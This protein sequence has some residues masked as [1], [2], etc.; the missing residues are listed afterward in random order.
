MLAPYPRA[1]EFPADPDAERQV[2]ALKAVVLGIRQ[3][4]GELDVPHSRS[5][6]VFVQT[7]REGDSAALAALAG[8]IAKVANLESV[9]VVASE[10]E[11]PPCAI[12]IIDGR[13]IFAPFARLV[14]DVSELA[15]SKTAREGRPG[16]RQVPRSR[17]RQLRRNAPPEVPGNMSAWRSSSASSSSSASR[18][19][20][21]PRCSPRESDGERG[22]GGATRR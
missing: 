14:D 12:A 1:D 8:T 2:A 16:A 17:Q 7:T 6:P 21:W 5:T 4:R 15:R 9:S 22:H 13:A 3:I 20:G 10:A 11:L 19:G 18:C